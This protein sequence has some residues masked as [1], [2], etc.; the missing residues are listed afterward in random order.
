MGITRHPLFVDPG[1]AE[2]FPADR[3]LVRR[4]Q[5]SFAH[6]ATRDEELTIRFYERLFAVQPALRP[7][8]PADMGQQ[9]EKLFATLAEVVAHLHD[10]V[11]SKR[12][13]EDLGRAHAGYGALERHYPIVCDCL[14]SALAQ[15]SGT[16]WDAELD[17][18]WRRLL[19]MLSAIMIRG[20][21]QDVG[22]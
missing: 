10:P 11:K 16:Q 22:R 14:A 13:L 18:E 12:L 7:M 6:A 1:G 17:A 19:E 2:E 4:L 15:V 21:R 5:A 9:R 3:A 8:F 20:A